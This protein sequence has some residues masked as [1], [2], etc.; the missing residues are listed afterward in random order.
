MEIQSL[1]L[2]GNYLRAAVYKPY[3]L[4]EETKS[5]SDEILCLRLHSKTAEI[6]AQNLSLEQC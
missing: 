5:Q 2:P 1:K 4:D 3:V 6:G